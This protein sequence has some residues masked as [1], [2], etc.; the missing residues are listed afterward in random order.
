MRTVYTNS[1]RALAN[2]TCP[3][4][5]RRVCCRRQGRDSRAV[6]H[7]SCS[8]LYGRRPPETSCRKSCTWIGPLSGP[9]GFLLASERLSEKLPAIT[10]IGVC[11]L[12]LFSHLPVVI[13]PNAPRL[14]EIS[15]LFVR[16]V[17]RGPHRRPAVQFTSARRNGPCITGLAVGFECGADVEGTRALS[18]R[19]IGRVAIAS[20]TGWSA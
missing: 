17:M 16:H 13:D 9:L 5:W 12:K 11:R 18:G 14:V 8:A 20:L 10:N 19:K 6:H 1:T 2:R 7:N 3:A 4:H 15:A